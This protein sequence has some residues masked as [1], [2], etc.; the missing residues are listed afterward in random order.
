MESGGIGLPKS[1][2]LPRGF[3]G[4]LGGDLGIHR[5]ALG[6]G[7]AVRSVRVKQE[8]RGGVLRAVDDVADD[9]R[10][11]DGEAPADAGAGVD[12]LDP[13]GDG[14]VGE[15]LGH[16]DGIGQPDGIG[17]VRGAEAVDEQGHGD[18]YQWT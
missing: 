3:D 7:G 5:H 10:A 13:V 15:L 1:E 17:R 9:G 8:R 12:L 18:P 4:Q 11:V 2:R 6:S 16:G 14:G